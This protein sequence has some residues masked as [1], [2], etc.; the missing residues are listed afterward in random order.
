MNE[1]YIKNMMFENAYVQM[2]DLLD[3]C[4]IV[5]DKKENIIL[6]NKATEALDEINRHEVIGGKFSEIYKA[7]NCSSSTLKCLSTG[8]VV[9][10]MY[11][12][13][14]TNTGKNIMT[15]SSS[16]P[17]VHKNRVEGVI[18]VTKDI[19]KYEEMMKIYRSYYSKYGKDGRY[20]NND[21]HYRFDDIIGKN[22]KLQE[23]IEM[24]KSAAR[25]NTNILIYGETG[26]GKELYAQSMHHE[27]GVSG[28]F[29]SLNC[30]AIPENLLESLLFGTVSG[31]Y[32][33]AVNK[34]GL[35][36]EA[37]KGTLFL[38]ELNSMSMNLQAKIL[39]AIET[40]KI[41]RVGENKERNIQ[42]RIISTTNAHP[43]KAI[44]DGILRRD[45]YYRL[46]AITIKIP[47]LRERLDD[48]PILAEFFINKY[49]EKYNKSIKGLD[50]KTLEMFESYNWPGNVREFEHNIEH[51][52]IMET[53]D[54]I[55]PN[56]LPVFLVEAVEHKHT[57][58]K[59]PTR[60]NAG[61]IDDIDEAM[62]EIESKIIYEKLKKNEFNVSNTAKELGL[63][64]QTLDYRIKKY[65]IEIR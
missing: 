29:V 61:N 13:Y 54:Y 60:Y 16:Y 36:E 47:P 26:T 17:L 38:D 30:A 43:I 32:T 39:R 18:T 46:G 33:G 63:S 3:D 7:N 6:I 5:V 35:F 8:K 1:I 40:G 19:T 58:K 28:G 56:N 55:Q 51:C 14:V 4:I 15:I 59:V 20:S 31:A 52:I 65:G 53:G 37:D 48:I 12:D 10:D 11:Q 22:K 45:L 62:K 50:D 57:D 23:T 34:A 25:A 24:A 42:T 2:F 27:S 21:T 41:R 64:R 49:N 44:E 9:K